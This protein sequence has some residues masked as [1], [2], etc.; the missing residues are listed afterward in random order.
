MIGSFKHQY[1]RRYERSRAW[2]RPRNFAKGDEPVGA[3][4]GG[5]EPPVDGSQTI[6][7][8]GLWG[9]GAG[10]IKLAAEDHTESGISFNSS[11]P[12]ASLSG[13]AHDGSKGRAN[14]FGSQGVRIASQVGSVPPPDNK[15]ISGVEIYVQDDKEI[16][17][18]QGL[19][20]TQMMVM[21]HSGTTLTGS[22]EIM[23]QCNQQI[24]LQVAGG[25]SSITLTATGIVMKGPLIQIN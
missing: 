7:F 9:V 15:S 16:I 10:T 24:T 20:G 8:Q 12:V 13:I 3:G 4:S 14:V 19:Y 17:F 21:A 18:Q 25:V 2:A 22:T 6:Y 1:S 5:G 11:D 23:I